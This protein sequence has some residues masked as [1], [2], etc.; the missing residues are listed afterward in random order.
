[1]HQT[2]KGNN[3][4]FGMKAR[5]GVDAETGLVHSLQTTSANL[6]DLTPVEELLTGEESTI[7]ADAGYRAAER[8]TQTQAAWH[9]AMRPC[10][11]RTLTEYAQDPI[12]DQL[13]K[14]KAR[15]RAKVEH[16]F[17]VIMIQFGFVKARYRGTAKNRA[18]LHC[19]LLLPTFTWSGDDLW[20]WGRCVQSVRKKT[21]SAE[22]TK[23]TSNKP[24]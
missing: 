8:R 22:K 1:M 17:R 4:N 15:V 2:K 13:E 9:I 7:L 20:P 10:K 14:L 24:D 3:W 5:I 12:T 16:P 18:Q 11:R 23:K 21:R 19:S 6:H